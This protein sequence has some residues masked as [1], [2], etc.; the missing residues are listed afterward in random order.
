V[1]SLDSYNDYFDHVIDFGLNYNWDVDGT[2]TSQQNDE[3]YTL[4][5][6]QTTNKI[7]Q[8]SETLVIQVCCERW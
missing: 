5:L 4:S 8:L 7:L 2:D 3:S 6:S 1:E